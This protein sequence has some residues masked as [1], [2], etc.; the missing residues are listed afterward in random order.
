VL[1]LL[2]L[3]CTLMIATCIAIMTTSWE[4]IVLFELFGFNIT[5][6][7]LAFVLTLVGLCSGGG[8]AYVMWKSAGGQKQLFVVGER[9]V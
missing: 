8:L 7:G 4:S 5:V 2:L 6:I 3:A 1:I 9:L